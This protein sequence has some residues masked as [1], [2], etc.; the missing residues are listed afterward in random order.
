MVLAPVAFIFP[1]LWLIYRP[2]LKIAWLA[3]AAVVVLA[4][5]YPYLRFQQTRDFADLKSL[6]QRQTMTIAQ[7]KDSWC[8]PTLVLRRL[9]YHAAPAELAQLPLEAPDASIRQA[10]ALSV[11]QRLKA[12]IAR[13]S[14]I[15][16]DGFTFNFDQMTWSRWAALPL[17]LLAMLPLALIALRTLA[18]YGLNDYHVWLARLAWLSLFVGVLFNEFF[19]AFF[20]SADGHLESFSTL[21]IRAIQV[22]LLTAGAVL[23]WRKEQIARRLR[24]M[25]EV[26]PVEP[27]HQP[28]VR[29]LFAICLLV[30]WIGLLT[31]VELGRPERYWWLWPF[32]TVAIVAAVT[33]L[34]DQLKWRKSVTLAGQA[35]LTILLLAHSWLI[36]PVQAWTRD[37]WS[38]PRAK[39]I[40]AVDYLAGDIRAEGRDK[41]AVGYQTIT[42]GF[43]PKLNFVDPRYKVGADLDLYL[44]YRYGISNNDQ[45]AEGFSADDEYRIVEARRTLYQ[46]EDYFSIE[47]DEYFDVPVDP[48]FRPLQQF[49]NYQ[50]FKRVDAAQDY[51]KQHR[52]RFSRLA[53]D[54]ASKVGIQKLLTLLNH[55]LVENGGVA[56]V[57][58]GGTG[59]GSF[60][61]G[62]KSFASANGRF[63][64]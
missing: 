1:A 26:R 31:V 10:E 18:F 21:R 39:I 48:G 54:C 53:L 62:L 64:R 12:R 38:G 58:D 29:R 57:G 32:Q 22:V 15:L 5:W 44:K 35:G 52:H 8:V 23:L 33:Y 37:G 27:S 45:C 3:A 16:M 46:P 13:T 49:G 4:V 7:Y 51:L 55:R 24:Q 34:P 43:V 60:S 20:V 59:A 14:G 63:G 41:V 11:S 19:I 17:C 61:F 30:P 2:R 6:V 50:V 56:F 36:A 25:T 9:Q 40:E 28:N 47:P 42:Y